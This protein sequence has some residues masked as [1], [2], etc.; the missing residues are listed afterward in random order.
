MKREP[1]TDNRLRILTERPGRTAF[2]ETLGEGLAGLIVGLLRLAIV[3][4]IIA[5]TVAAFMR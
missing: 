3:A 5:A 4:A 2:N 1:D